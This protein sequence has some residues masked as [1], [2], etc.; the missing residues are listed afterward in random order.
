LD[1]PPSFINRKEIYMA[2]DLEVR[3]ENRMSSQSDQSRGL[4]P[5]F[6][7]MIDRFFGNRFDS[8]LGDFPV[9]NQSAIAD[10]RENDK[11]YVLSIEV[12]GI[13][14]EDIDISVSGNLLS[15]RA[16]R[17]EEEGDKK[18]FR[19]QYRSIQQS[20]SL[21]TTVDSDKVE[22]QLD[23]GILEVMLPKVEQSQAKKIEVQAKRSELSQSEKSEAGS[24][25]SKSPSTESQQTSAPVKH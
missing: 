15:V 14:M 5:D 8:L 17:K 7:N 4:L 10:I 1:E 25:S 24:K 13:P 20:F 2:K 6:E 19:R 22:A 12:P 3:K 16:E 18:M 9:M 11:A 21:P 23:C